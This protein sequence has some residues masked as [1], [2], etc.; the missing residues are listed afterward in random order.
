MTFNGLK[1]SQFATYNYLL[2]A[3][4]TRPIPINEIA[5]ITNYE[6]TTISKALRELEKMQLIKRN[7]PYNWQPYYF[8]VIE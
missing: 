7:R 8:Q 3:D 6:Y 2:Q 5:T 1:G 4:L